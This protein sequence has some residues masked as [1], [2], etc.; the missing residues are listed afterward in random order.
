MS[1]KRF[2]VGI[3]SWA[4]DLIL[5]TRDVFRYGEYW[6]L[7]PALFQDPAGWVRSPAALTGK[8]EERH[9]AHVKAQQEVVASE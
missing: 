5:D 1:G 9:D 3:S 8:W 7:P 6:N 4:E 2:I